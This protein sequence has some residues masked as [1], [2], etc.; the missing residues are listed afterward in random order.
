MSFSFNA[1]ANGLSSLTSNVTYGNKALTESTN[2]WNSVSGLFG[3]NSSGSNTSGSTSTGKVSASGS[4]TTIIMNYINHYSESG[5]LK[6]IYKKLFSELSP[7]VSGYTLLFMVPPVLSGFKDTLGNSN[8]NQ[9]GSSFFG[10]F[11]KITPLLATTYTPPS[12]QLNTSALSGSSGTQHFASELNITDNMTVTYVDTINLDVYAMHVTWLDYIYQILEGTLKP[13]Q[14]IIDKR[15]I[16]YAASFYF[17]KWQPDM[18]TL[19]YIGKATGC[20]P[21]ELPSGDVI[22]NRSANEFT[23]VTFNYTV[24]DYREATINQS[25]NWL[26]SELKNIILSQY[27][28]TNGSS[29]SSISATK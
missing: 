23:N 11:A 17:V 25:S 7:D 3:G 10:Q 1:I 26:F 28:S 8:Y 12:I 19:Q 14:D 5:P 29:S 16:D 22:G 20:F 2:A 21:K 27:E 6:Y 4:P 15:I 24:S 13:S 9:F 18:E